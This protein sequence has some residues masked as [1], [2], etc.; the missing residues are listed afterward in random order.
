MI[1]KVAHFPRLQGHL[2]DLF[3]WF[4]LKEEQL[5]P[6]LNL[7]LPYLK[8]LNLYLIV[9]YCSFAFRISSIFSIALLFVFLLLA[10]SL[11]LQLLLPPRD[12]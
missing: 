11:E 8:H 2:H 10:I 6:S 1:E 5:D 12:S 3:L 9:F 7:G 4:Y